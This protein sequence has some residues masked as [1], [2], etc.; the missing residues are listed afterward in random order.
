MCGIAGLLR[1]DGAPVDRELA[2]PDDRHPRPSRARRRWV[3]RRRARSA[4]AT[5]GSRSSTSAAGAP[6]D[7]H[8]GRI[9]VDHL[10]R[11]D[12]QLPRAAPRARAR[13]GVTLPHAVRHRGA[14]CTA[15]EAWGASASTRLRGMFAFAIWDE[16]AAPLLLARDR[17]GIKP[18]RLRLG[19]PRRLRFASELKAILEDP[20][21]RGELDCDGA[22]AT[23]SPTSTSRPRGRSSGRIRKL[24]PASYLRSL[25]GDEPRD[26]RA[27]GTSRIAPERRARRGRAGRGARRAARRGGR[28]AHGERRAG[29][30]LPRAAAS[31]RARSWPACAGLVRRRSQTFS[32]GFDEEDFDELALRPAVAE[33]S[34][35]TTRAG[36]QARRDERAAAAGLALRRAVRGLLRH[37]HLLRSQDRPRARHRG[38]DRRRRR[39]ALRRLPALRRRR[40]AARRMDRTPLALLKPPL[41]WAGARRAPGAR[42]RDFLQA[43]RARPASIG[44]R[45]MLVYQ[46]AADAGRAAHCGRRAGADDDIEA[47]VP[48]L[49]G[50]RGRERG[51]DDY[52]PRL[53]YLD[54][55]HYLPE[56]ILAEGGPASM[57]TLA[58]EPRAPPRSRGHGARGQDAER[59]SSY[60]TEAASTS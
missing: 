30:R 19:R 5:G 22:R 57:L 50:G 46:T 35:P 23:T 9:A 20:R 41:R 10:Q 6:A 51:P 48:R 45:R 32:I 26:R 24:P 29:R 7:G 18:L 43:A 13:A 1:R 2:A 47:A 58:G 33:P 38:A 15:Y 59:R 60:A 49:A 28:A 52:S 42:G 3:P 40:A 12:L 31:T 37:P 27:T 36:A 55:H 39:R 44:T 21:S 14:C 34:A 54:V 17:V 56:D 53:Q 11:R 25:D 16:R 4:S 8:D